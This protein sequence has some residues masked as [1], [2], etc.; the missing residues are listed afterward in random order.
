M[1]RGRSVRNR[2]IEGEASSNQGA[3]SPHDQTVVPTQTAPSRGPTPTTQ[4]QNEVVSQLFPALR[5][6]HE[7]IECLAGQTMQDSVSTPVPPLVGPVIDEP[8]QGV[9]L[10]TLITY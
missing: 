5:A 10:Q 2:A 8:I 1:A 7:A 4:L 9:T 3:I 6:I